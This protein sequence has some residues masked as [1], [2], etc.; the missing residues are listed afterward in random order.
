LAGG[1]NPALQLDPI[2]IVLKPDNSPDLLR[3]FNCGGCE[4]GFT[5]E[6]DTLTVIVAYFDQNADVQR[7]TLVATNDRG[8]TMFIPFTP[9][10]V[11]ALPSGSRGFALRVRLVGFAG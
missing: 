2:T 7:L 6:G 10:T 9:E 4:A 1:V 5:Q 3:T 8:Q 11:P